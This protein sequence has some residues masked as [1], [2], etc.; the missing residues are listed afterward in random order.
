[1]YYQQF[2]EIL[3]ANLLEIC[4]AVGSACFLV[5]SGS[6]FVHVTTHTHPHAYAAFLAVTLCTLHV[7]HIWTVHVYVPCIDYWHILCR[8]MPCGVCVYICTEK[9]V[10]VYR[11]LSDGT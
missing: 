11:I 4:I 7:V 8:G 1:M 9:H 3:L 5:L 2:L 10:C 6:G